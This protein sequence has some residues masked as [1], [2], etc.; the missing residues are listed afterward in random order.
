MR[1]YFVSGQT[2]NGW[3]WGKDMLLLWRRLLEPILSSHRP[4]GGCLTTGIAKSLKRMQVWCASSP[5]TP[6]PAAW[7]SPSVELP[8]KLMGSGRGS[9]GALG[10]PAWG[11]RFALSL[12]KKSSHPFW[13]VFRLEGSDDSY[14]FVKP[15]WVSWSIWSSLKAEEVYIDSGSLGQACPAHPRN[16]FNLQD[17]S[18]DWNFNKADGNNVESDDWE[19]GGVAIHCSVHKNWLQT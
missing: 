1:I 2:T 17:G 4:Q 6:L 14:L 15:G 11:E 18:K 19:D 12:V 3:L 10:W 16:A 5:Q 7:Q 8:K 9:T 13:Q